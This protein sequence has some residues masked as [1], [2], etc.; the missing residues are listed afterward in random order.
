LSHPVS[1]T[2]Y[3]I[4]IKEIINEII[5]EQVL[6]ERYLSAPGGILIKKRHIY[7]VVA[8]RTAIVMSISTSRE[9]RYSGVFL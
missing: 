1:I 5:N 9:K 6:A 2:H 3:I 8:V 7:R 4:K